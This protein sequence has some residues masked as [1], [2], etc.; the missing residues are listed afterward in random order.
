MS[1]I[2]HPRFETSGM[3]LSVTA[4]AYRVLDA[5][6]AERRNPRYIGAAFIDDT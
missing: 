5:F 6:S 4:T 2:D 1:G 3:L